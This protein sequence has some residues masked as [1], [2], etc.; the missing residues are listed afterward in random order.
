MIPNMQNFKKI[1]PFFSRTFYNC[2]N[3]IQQQYNVNK[4]G[5]YVCKKKIGNSSACKLM[6]TACTY[7]SNQCIKLNK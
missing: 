1:R 5:F 3:T 4:Y 7:I 6:Y 2:N